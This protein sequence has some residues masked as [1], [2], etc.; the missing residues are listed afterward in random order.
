MLLLPCLV[1]AEV[2]DLAGFMPVRINQAGI[3]AGTEGGHAFKRD[4]WIG[5]STDLGNLPGGAGNNTVTGLNL[6]GQVTGR[7]GTNGYL[8]TS[9]TMVQKGANS[10]ANGLN[11]HGDVA[12]RVFNVSANQSYAI[13]WNHDGTILRPLG[14][15]V[16]GEISEAFDV[17]DAGT[18]VGFTLP[19]SS[20]SFAFVYEA[21]TITTLRPLGMTR[22]L[23]RKVS[24][25]DAAHVAQGVPELVVGEASNATTQVAWV[26][27]GATLTQLPTLGGRSAALDVNQDGVIVGYSTAVVSGSSVAHAA[28]WTRN[29][30]GVWQITD[31]DALV[32][33][34]PGRILSSASGINDSGMIVGSMT[35]GG[36]V[37]GYCVN[38]VQGIDVARYAGWLRFDRLRQARIDGKAAYVIV[39]AFMGKSKNTYAEQQ[40]RI[41][42]AAGCRTAASCFMNFLHYGEPGWSGADQIGKALEACG[43]EASKIGFFAIDLEDAY[44]PGAAIRD[45]NGNVVRFNPG[46]NDVAKNL[47]IID[48][49]LAAIRSQGLVPIVY[50]KATDWNLICGALD[51]PRFSTLPLWVPRYDGVADLLIDQRAAWGPFGGWP[52][53][54]GKQF[55]DQRGSKGK[56][57]EAAL[58][59]PSVDVD[60]FGIGLL[61]D[62][63]LPPNENVVFLTGTSGRRIGFDQSTGRFRVDLAVANYGSVAADPV[64]VTGATLMAKGALAASGDALPADYPELGR[65]DPFAGPKPGTIRFNPAVPTG[66]EQEMELILRVMATNTG[67]TFTLNIPFRYAGVKI[68]SVSGPSSVPAGGTIRLLVRLSGP[69]PANGVRIAFTSS[70][71]SLTALQ[72]LTIPAGAT[73]GS[74]DVSA[75]VGASATTAT[76]TLASGATSA[77]KAIS[78]V[79]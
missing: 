8:W 26:W 34:A 12:G 62:L 46:T 66:A 70:S 77:T 20:G 67:E 29:A 56:E 59:S 30:A 37:H 53:R 1:G 68:L 49:A 44:V 45:P 73:E 65:I 63:G 72:I 11:K 71:P 52:Y 76:V 61:G 57:L 2:I 60:L 35:V 38:G 69:A 22:C 13:V 50:T 39:G 28:M 64:T 36:A 3:L 55:S 47:A 79:P 4:L 41:A 14:L 42:R 48:E 5:E 9:G 74:L 6:V 27:D 33:S 54:V 51:D 21:G 10:W 58:N 75:G 31:L 32:G 78:I 17:S 40:L 7:S 24:S 19:G 15:P 18:V 16:N 43:T 25:P 23:A